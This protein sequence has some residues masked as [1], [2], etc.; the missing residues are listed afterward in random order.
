MHG[1]L[2]LL[3]LS[4]CAPRAYPCNRHDIDRFPHSLLTSGQLNVYMA[5]ESFK[6][7]RIPA[8]GSLPLTQRKGNFSMRHFDVENGQ[9]PGQRGGVDSPIVSQC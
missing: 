3:S 2:S 6:S 5:V 4:L 9:G 7:E 1:P 8:K